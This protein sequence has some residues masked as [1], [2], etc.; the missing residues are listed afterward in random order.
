M[1]VRI[2][3]SKAYSTECICYKAMNIPHAS[4]LH[5]FHDGPFAQN[6]KFY[7]STFISLCSVLTGLKKKATASGSPT[8]ALAIY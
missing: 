8:D 3:P 7:Q 4:C 2:D 6:A 1:V 5:L